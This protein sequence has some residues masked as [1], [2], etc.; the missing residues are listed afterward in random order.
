MISDSTELLEDKVETN[1]FSIALA[2]QKAKKEAN[3]SSTP[4]SPVRTPRKSSSLSRTPNLPRSIQLF[5]ENYSQNSLSNKL[6]SKETATE[7]ATATIPQFPVR[8]LFSDV[9]ES[10]NRGTSIL[11]AIEERR[12]LR[13]DNEMK[14]LE[15]KPRVLFVKS[16][17]DDGLETGYSVIV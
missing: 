16:E 8:R 17:A 7:G 2:R 11:K 12:K 6:K 5:V 14:T 1:P 15:I 13:R 10:D 3:Q 9:E 4:A